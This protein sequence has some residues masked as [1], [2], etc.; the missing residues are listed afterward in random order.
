M[1]EG[2]NEK[3][4]EIEQEECPC[5]GKKLEIQLYNEWIV[6]YHPQGIECSYKFQEKR[7]LPG[8]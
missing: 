6:H 4:K 2:R 5:C 7:E 8:E 3:N 1:D